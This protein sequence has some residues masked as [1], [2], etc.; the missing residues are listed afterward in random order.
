MHFDQNKGFLN[1]CK[2]VLSVRVFSMNVHPPMFG[3]CQ[4]TK[5]P[6]ILNFQGQSTVFSHILQVNIIITHVHI[7]F[8]GAVEPK[9]VLF[10]AIS[11]SILALEK[12]V[13]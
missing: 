6:E 2:I 10:L 5:S 11:R 13:T 8:G 12:I 4:T 9:L 7:P 1:G 3:C